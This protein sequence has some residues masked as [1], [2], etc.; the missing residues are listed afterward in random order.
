MKKTGAWEDGNGAA[1][2]SID[3]S[4]GT[5]LVKRNFSDAAVVNIDIPT[6]DK[7]SLLKVDNKMFHRKKT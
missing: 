6:R 7:I 2:N 1:I 5:I 4:K 3:C